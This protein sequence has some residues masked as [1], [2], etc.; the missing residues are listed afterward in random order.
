MPSPRALRAS[1]REA[2]SATA[3]SA[4]APAAA[5]TPSPRDAA[6]QHAM[7]PEGKTVFAFGSSGWV[8]GAPRQPCACRLHLVAAARLC[9]PR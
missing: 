8:R 3:A 6:P 7:G 4:P 2:A 9:A 5:S 1:A